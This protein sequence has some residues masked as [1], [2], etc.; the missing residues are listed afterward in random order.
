MPRNSWASLQDETASDSPFAGEASR[1]A[2]APLPESLLALQRERA[3]LEA[4]MRRLASGGAEPAGEGD[5]RYPVTPL[6]QRR[7]A[8]AAWASR[9]DALSARPPARE[10]TPAEPGVPE[11]AADDPTLPLRTGQRLLGDPPPRSGMRELWRSWSDLEALDAGARRVTAGLEAWERR[12]RE[13]LEAPPVN[14]STPTRAYE[15]RRERL[16]SVVDG[17]SGDLDGRAEQARERALER[18]REQRR[19]QQADDQR[20]ARARRQRQAQEEES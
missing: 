5:A 18:R 6:S 20:L 3:E 1:P 17:G 19:E 11:R 7:R 8:D 4:K 13:A 12:G 10:L 2:S 9:R 16:L 14:P 15:A